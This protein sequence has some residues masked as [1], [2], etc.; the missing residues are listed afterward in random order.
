MGAREQPDAQE[1]PG[2][3]LA[4]Q[5]SDA[6]GETLREPELLGEAPESHCPAG[7]PAGGQAK[8]LV[9]A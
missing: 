6:L 5:A 7:T 1:L 4:S 9:Q 3:P 2:A 8:G